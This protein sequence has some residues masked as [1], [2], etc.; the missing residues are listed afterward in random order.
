MHFFDAFELIAL[1]TFLLL[2][3]GRTLQ[4]RIGR[5]IRVYNMVR[6]KP[7]SEA[8]LELL[9]LVAFPVWLVEVVVHAAGLSFDLLPAAVDP[10]LVSG[11]APAT[12]GAALQVLGIGLFA[13]SLAS[14]GESWRVGVDQD[15]PGALVTGGVFRWSRNPIFSAMDLFLFGTFLLNGRLFSLAF[16][17]G[18][19]IGFHRQ[20]LNEERFLASRYGA[21]YRTYRAR[22]GRYLGR[23]A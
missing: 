11:T 13:W 16:A 4:L 1:A 2:F 8:A 5:G 15:A 21:A 20:I 23:A 9:F 14:F 19:S 3:I 6:G 17:L 18:S 12:L 22:V 7:F 10:V